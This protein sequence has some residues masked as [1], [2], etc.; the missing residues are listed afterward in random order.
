MRPR[1]QPFLKANFSS[2]ATGEGYH[3]LVRSE[4]GREK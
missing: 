1:V 2:S 3:R 4:S